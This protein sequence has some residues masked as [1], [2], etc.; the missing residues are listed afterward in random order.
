MQLRILS[1]LGAK[2]AI[3]ASDASPPQKQQKDITDLNIA[4]SLPLGQ[5]TIA[6]LISKDPVASAPIMPL[7]SWGTPNKEA[8]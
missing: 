2:F 6:V 5:T 8:L 3:H 7:K 1:P 4:L